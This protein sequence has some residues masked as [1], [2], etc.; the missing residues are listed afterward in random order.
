MLVRWGCR[1]AVIDV[2][3]VALSHWWSSLC[4]FRVLCFNL[5]TPSRYFSSSLSVGLPLS[6][7]DG[8]CHEEN[9]NEACGTFHCGFRKLGSERLLQEQR[10]AI[11]G[12][13]ILP[14][15]CV[16]RVNSEGACLDGGRAPCRP[17]DSVA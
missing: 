8:Y 15:V 17:F 6:T 12:S 9:N 5:T 11:Y 10:D 7:G 14:G 13:R 1:C 2:L 4:D 16:F 3:N